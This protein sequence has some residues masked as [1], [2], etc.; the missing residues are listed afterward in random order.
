[1]GVQYIYFEVFNI[2]E[3]YFFKVV[4]GQSWCLMISVG[5]Y[6]SEMV[7]NDQC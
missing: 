7:I 4:I 5:D 6:L 3:V 1:M 2:N